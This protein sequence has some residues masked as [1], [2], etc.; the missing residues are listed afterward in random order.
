MR[1]PVKKKIVKRK[2]TNKVRYIHPPLTKKRKGARVY[3]TDVSLKRG[4]G[5]SNTGGMAGGYFWHIYYKAER[6]GKIYVNYNKSTKQADIQIFINQKSQG[7]G[8]GRIAYRKACEESKYTEI[9]AT[10]R[11]NNIAS[12]RAASAAGFTMIPSATH[13]V[14]MLWSQIKFPINAFEQL[15]QNLLKSNY[16]DFLLFLANLKPALRVKIYEEEIKTS[17]SNWC[18]ENSFN[19]LDD[20]YN[21]IYIAKSKKMVESLKQIDNSN[22]PHESKLGLLLGYPMCCCEKISYVGEA[23]ID[24][25]EESLIN[26]EIFKGKFELINPNGYRNGYALLSHIPCSPTCINSLH[27]AQKVLCIIACYKDN[28]HFETWQNNWHRYLQNK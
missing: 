26:N 24:K 16:I 22:T 13:Q 1:Q 9:Y 10:M 8:I 5:A 21:Y 7:Q 12:I 3:S 20:E 6:A 17:L 19:F 28:K 18:K 15:P 25:W 2:S 11:K 23:N 4:R 14:A 27:I